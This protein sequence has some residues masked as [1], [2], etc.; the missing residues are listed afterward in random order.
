VLEDEK[1]VYSDEAKDL[2]ATL[3]QFYEEADL[4]TRKLIKFQRMKNM[5]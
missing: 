3:P 1:G 2:I 5:L 4:E